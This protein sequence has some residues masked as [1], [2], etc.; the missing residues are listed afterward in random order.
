MLAL[1]VVYALEIFDARGT[2]ASTPAF[3]DKRLKKIRYVHSATIKG[4][5]NRIADIFAVAQLE[6]KRPNDDVTT[7]RLVSLGVQT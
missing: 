3:I 7:V 1:R 2:D 6:L 5:L 4:R